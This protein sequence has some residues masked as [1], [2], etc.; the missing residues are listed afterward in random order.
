I[1]VPLGPVRLVVVVAGDGTASRAIA[2]PGRAVGGG[3]LLE[4]AALVLVVPQGQDE[5]GAERV[6]DAHRLLVTAGIAR[7]GGA[8]DVARGGGEEAERARH[9][10]RP[11]EASSSAGLRRKR[12]RL[13]RLC[14]AETTSMEKPLWSMRSPVRGTRPKAA[15]TRP[16]TVSTLSPS[17]RT[18]SR[19]CS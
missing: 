3:V 5:V 1:E 14:S 9:H 6:D 19:A 7:A 15:A 11:H 10:A 8:G 18:V 16:P 4:G 2:A 17:A 13:T 12:T